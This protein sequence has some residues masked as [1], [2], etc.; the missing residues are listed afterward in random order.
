MALV[1]FF[2]PDPALGIAE[3]K[4][5]VK[6]EG[7]IAAYVRDIPGEGLPLDL[8][9]REFRKK[10][11]EYPLPPNAE[12]SKMDQLEKLW[13]ESGLRS[14]ECKQIKVTRSFASFDEFWNITAS[15]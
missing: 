2:V 11:I 15:V 13:T 4:R 12:V 5:V 1:L 9:H 6:P 10:G 14:T 7:T 3:M 8:I